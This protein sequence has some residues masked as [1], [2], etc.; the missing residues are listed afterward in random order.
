MI[1]QAGERDPLRCNDP[2][3]VWCGAEMQYFARSWLVKNKAAWGWRREFY[4][5]GRA[6]RF[7]QTRAPE[8]LAAYEALWDP[9]LRAD[10]FRYIVILKE[11]G[12]YSDPDTMCHRR[13]DTDVGADDRMVVG[14]EHIMESFEAAHAGR[15][16]SPRPIQVLQWTFLAEREH[17]AVLE[18][19]DKVA[20][21]ILA[22]R[23]AAGT[24]APPGPGPAF[25]ARA[26][27]AVSA[28]AAKE[29]TGPGPFTDTVLQH[30]QHHAHGIRI[31]SQHKWGL[32]SGHEF[33][34]AATVLR[35]FRGAGEPAPGAHG[36]AGAQAAAP[37]HPPDWDPLYAK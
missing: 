6:L 12:V 23:H 22:D 14:L 34:H 2:T 3:D 26:R 24:G 37:L 18:V 21:A 27:D 9:A 35:S 10:F 33:A 17:P 32:P 13:L 19:C 15:R 29:L 16:R 5:D 28:A 31:L 1:H 4:D 7:V 11:G 20:A 36:A 25:S 30:L 8:Y